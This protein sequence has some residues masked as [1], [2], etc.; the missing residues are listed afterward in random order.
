MHICFECWISHPDDFTFEDG[1]YKFMPSIAFDG[2]PERYVLDGAT[3]YDLWR[4]GGDLPLTYWG[5]HKDKTKAHR[6]CHRVCEIVNMIGGL[7]A[8]RMNRN[9]YLAFATGKKK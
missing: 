5:I 4:I 7:D 8:W 3:I 9:S 6:L 1:L 2:E